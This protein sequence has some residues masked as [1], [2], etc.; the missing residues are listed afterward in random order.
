ML[1]IAFS[2][3]TLLCTLDA[4]AQW[5]NGYNPY[6]NLGASMGNAI[7]EG[8][9]HNHNYGR[10]KLCKHIDKWG[11]CKNAS[12]T[13]NH[14]AVAIYDSNG[15]FCSATTPDHVGQRL[16]T[17]NKNNETIDDV[18]ITEGGHYVVVSNKGKNWWG[19]MPDAV[20]K[21]LKEIS[22][23]ESIRSVSFTDNGTYAIVTDMHFFSNSDDYMNFFREKKNDLGVLLSANI[24]GNGAVFCFSGGSAFCG[25]IP[26]VVSEAIKGVSFTPQYVKFNRQGHY[27]ICGENGQF[28]Y[29]IGNANPSAT[30]ATVSYKPKVT[31][32]LVE[33]FPYF[34]YIDINNGEPDILN[35][36]GNLVLKGKDIKEHAVVFDL[37]SRPGQIVVRHTIVDKRTGASETRQTFDITPEETELKVSSN[38]IW[39]TF[40]QNG[41]EKCIRIVKGQKNAAMESIIWG[42][43]LVSGKPH[44]GK[45]FIS[46]K[47]LL[48]TTKVLGGENLQAMFEG[49]VKGWN[50]SQP[51]DKRLHMDI[52][53]FNEKFNRLKQ[54]L[55]RYKWQKKY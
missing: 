25:T 2:A 5:G 39:M 21:K 38:E 48:E 30:A 9:Q 32:T 7:S 50:D 8:I 28:S 26:S 49:A 11:S 4:H 42:D 43:K 44:N 20:V 17:I 31:S 6:Y 54:E 33:E 1:F 36:M 45:G 29:S 35:W 27:I 3:L 41:V 34:T 53:D 46:A 13:I 47:D 40:K 18:N 52:P 12:L 10:R 15:Y 51:A 23:L 14:G 37:K 24:N 16:K 22:S 19:Y 55:Q